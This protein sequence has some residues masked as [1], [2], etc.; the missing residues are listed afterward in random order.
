MGRSL[1]SG[2]D[3]CKEKIQTRDTVDAMDL[4]ERALLHVTLDGTG[5]LNEVRGLGVS[6]FDFQEAFP[7]GSTEGCKPVGIRLGNKA[8]L[9]LSEERGEVLVDEAEFSALEAKRGVMASHLEGDQTEV[10]GRVLSDAPRRELVLALIRNDVI[11]ANAHTDAELYLLAEAEDQAGY[12]STWVSVDT[13]FTNQKNV[14]TYSFGV[15][16][17]ADG[18][19]LFARGEDVGA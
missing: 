16:V 12:R 9:W 7:A 18:R 17:E 2:T 13:F 5:Y 19:I 15:R 11:Q 4:S 14:V 8:L 10:I 6:L 3:R 1:G